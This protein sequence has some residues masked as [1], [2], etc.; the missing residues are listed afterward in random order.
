MS[1][2]LTNFDII[3]ISTAA[4]TLL[5]TNTWNSLFKDIINSYFPQNESN[6]AITAQILYTIILTFFIGIIVYIVRKYGGDL[7]EKIQKF[8]KKFSLKFKIKVPEIPNAI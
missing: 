6:K 2:Q 3:T 5:V 8:I 4:M 7:N 1:V